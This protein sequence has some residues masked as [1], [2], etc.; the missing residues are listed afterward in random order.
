MISVYCTKRIK[1][2]NTL[3]AKWQRILVLEQVAYVL[4]TKLWRVKYEIVMDG[5]NPACTFWRLL[6]RTNYMLLQNY[7]PSLKPIW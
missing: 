4:T 2:T 7:N 3:Y 1:L 6:P 5:Q